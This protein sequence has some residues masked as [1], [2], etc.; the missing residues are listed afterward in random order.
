MRAYSKGWDEVV[1]FNLN[2]SLEQP[3]IDSTNCK[4]LETKVPISS[5]LIKDYKIQSL[6]NE[7][8]MNFQ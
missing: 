8:E 3:E 1:H 6:M 4:I 5:E 7:N 2:Q